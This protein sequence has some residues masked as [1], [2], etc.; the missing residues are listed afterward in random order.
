[1]LKINHLQIFRTS[2]ATYT[3][4]LQLSVRMSGRVLKISAL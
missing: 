3:T 2:R 1:V 4:F